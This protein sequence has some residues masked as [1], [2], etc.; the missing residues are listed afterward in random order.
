MVTNLKEKADNYI[1]FS[2]AISN[3]V[4][5]GQFH[6]LFGIKRK[7]NE[8]IRSGLDVDIFTT[9]LLNEKI[10]SFDELNDFLFNELFYGIH[11]HVYI[12]KIRNYKYDLTHENNV[13]RILKT[14]Y[15]IHEIDYNNI[16]STIFKHD[17]NDVK[18]VAVRVIKEANKIE[19]IRLIYGEKVSKLDGNKQYNENSYTCIEIDLRKNLIITKVAPK[20]NVI[21]DTKK[22]SSIE[23]KNTKDALGKFGIY[24]E[25]YGHSHR[26][27][28]F[29]ISK[30]LSDELF[31]K[32]DYEE[33]KEIDDL[34]SEFSRKIL[35]KINI[36]NMKGNSNANLQAQ[37]NKLIQQIKIT[38]ILE[39]TEIGNMNL[40]GKI[41]Y[42][43]FKDCDSVKAVLKSKRIR[44]SL[45]D[46]EAYFGLKNSIENSKELEMLRVV[47]YHGGEEVVIKHDASDINVL[48]MQFYT[49]LDEGDF[50][51]VLEKYEEFQRKHNGKI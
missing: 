35:D 20:S 24:T 41:S 14:C 25:V 34:I 38:S 30:S 44:E 1:V 22:P 39:E 26:E 46:S 16:S 6:K 42:L 48:F 5:K 18:L 19:K 13:L 47:W 45:A 9:Q 49:K 29:N 32:A 15:D 21:G 10:I 28:L 2:S 36:C 11:K 27:V 7:R 40:T 31:S 8:F 33:P 23:L 17:E 43:K 4:L 51:Y 12:R 50:Y 3:N 37:V